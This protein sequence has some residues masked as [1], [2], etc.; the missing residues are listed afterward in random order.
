M[1]EMVDRVRVKICGLKTLD[2]ALAAL[3]A[4]V[5]LL[6]FNFYRTSPRYVEPAGCARILAALRSRGSTAATVGVFVNASL[7]EIRA[8]LDECGLDLAQLHGDEPVELL[9][10]L[11]ERAFKAIRPSSPAAARASLARYGCDRRSRAPALLLDAAQPGLYGGTGQ[12]ADW[13]LAASLAA[14]YPILL[15]GGLTPQ[16]VAA[17]VRL[18][19]PWGV[20]VASG[21]ES[22]PGRKDRA[23]MFEFVAAV[24]R[25]E[26]DS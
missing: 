10:G 1:E 19:R 2:D 21:V 22:A 11:G 23:K 16:N 5:D 25:E 7:A 8:T 18:V 12:A 26:V 3:D 24:R 13:G 17:A 4:G 15:A 14:D 20:D 6:G 9:A